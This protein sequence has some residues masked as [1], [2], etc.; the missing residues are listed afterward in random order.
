[1]ACIGGYARA[2]AKPHESRVYDCGGVTCR[3]PEDPASPSPAG[4]YVVMCTVFYKCGFDVPS[5]QFLRSLL[6]SYGLELHHLT[7]LGILH[8]A[9]FVTLCEA[10]IGIDPNFNMW[11][12]FFWARLQQGLDMGAAALGNVDI[13]VCSGPKV[14]P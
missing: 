6:W 14:D 13:S 3:V 11:S 5:Q 10:Y 9:A 1:L 8:M 7:P 2:P 12:Y 4:G